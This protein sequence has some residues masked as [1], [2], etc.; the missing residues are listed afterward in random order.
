MQEKVK[1]QRAKYFISNNAGKSKKAK[2][3]EKKYFYIS[4]D[5]GNN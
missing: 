4:F 1:R 5:F 3:K 2:G